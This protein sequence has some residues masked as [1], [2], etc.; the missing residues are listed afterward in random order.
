[1]TTTYYSVTTDAFSTFLND[2]IISG[3]TTLDLTGWSV[4]LGTGNLQPTHETTDLINVIYD[5]DT[6]GYLGFTASVYASG[7]QLIS[8]PIPNSVLEGNII[9]EI[10]LYDSNDVLM[11]AAATYLDLTRTSAQGLQPNFIEQLV[12]KDI[13]SGVT[14]VYETWDDYQLRSEKNQ[15]NGYA[16]LDANAKVITSL[17]NDAGATQKGILKLFTDLLNSNEDGTATQKA[18]KDALDGKLSKDLDNLSSLGQAILDK[19]VE[20]EAL[21]QQN[22][23]A[24]FSWKENNQISKIIFIFLKSSFDSISVPA[25]SSITKVLNLPIIV[26]SMSLNWVAVANI[27]SIFCTTVSVTNS[28]VELR[29]NNASDSAKSVSRVNLIAITQ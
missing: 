11:C 8:I 29:L 12:L 7:G 19:K 23:Y 5:K 25:N 13:P 4:K 16:G 28:T 3:S 24:K 20:V 15:A 10:G 9:T 18:I 22:G 21:L 27:G 6:T 17:L 14:V 1:M 2:F 26:D